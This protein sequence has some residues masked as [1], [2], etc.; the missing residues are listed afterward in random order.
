MS[1]D[2]RSSRA[3]KTWGRFSPARVWILLLGVTACQ[4]N[5]I[6]GVG[7][8]FARQVDDGNC[9]TSLSSA[10]PAEIV[11]A[12]TGPLAFGLTDEIPKPETPREFETEFPARSFLVRIDAAPHIDGEKAAGVRVTLEEYDDETR[13]YLSETQL[14]V[15]AMPLMESDL[16]RFNQGLYLGTHFST[17]PRRRLRVRVEGLGIDALKGIAVTAERPLPAVD[18]EFPLLGSETLSNAGGY[19]PPGFSTAPAGISIIPRSAWGASEP[20]GAAERTTWKRIVI[21]H[22]AIKVNGASQCD[23]LVR[24]IQQGHLRQGW[25]D[26]GYHFLVCPDGRVFEG[27][28]GG[29]NIQGAHTKVLNEGTVGVNFLGQ[30]ESKAKDTNKGLDEPT[31]EALGSAARL[32]AWLARET[33]VNLEGAGTVAG[34]KSGVQLPYF[35][36]HRAVGEASTSSNDG[37]LCPGDRIIHQ[38][39][40]FKAL[41]VQFHSGQTVAGGSPGA[42]RQCLG[43]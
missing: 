16:N 5:V 11:T 26:I 4:E 29:K 14:V 1:G 41:A 32:V 8:R 31:S 30:F 18:T 38:F 23:S 21:H 28:K 24:S 39:S 9:L 40:Q 43:R 22:A 37:T 25:N 20:R 13:S 7:D 36:H 33:G 19:V 2:P 27:R 6:P 12:R 17:A 42:K 35:T 34:M 15:N 3:S 10:T